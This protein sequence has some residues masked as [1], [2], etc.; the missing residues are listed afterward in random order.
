M[1]SK[2]R[3]K[4]VERRVDECVVRDACGAAEPRKPRRTLAIVGKQAVRVST[5]HPTVR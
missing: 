5:D 3:G 4:I 1:R 2:V